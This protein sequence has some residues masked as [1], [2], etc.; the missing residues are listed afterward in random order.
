MPFWA[1]LS[2]K[3]VTSDK[4]FCFSSIVLFARLS[5]NR[6]MAVLIFDFIITFLS[7]RFSFC[8]IRFIADLILAMVSPPLFT[9]Y[10]NTSC[11][12]FQAN[13]L[14]NR[15]LERVLPLCIWNLVNVETKEVLWEIFCI[16]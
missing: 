15:R 8:F 9:P 13:L 2:N 11:F 10:F 12:E 6:R 4:R 16:W 7:R 1:A 5:L 3:L 14:R